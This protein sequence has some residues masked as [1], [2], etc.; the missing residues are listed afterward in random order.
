[1]GRE[2]IRMSIICAICNKK[3]S[4]WI[5]DFPVSK[6][7]IDKRI[8]AQCN[9]KLS[10]LLRSDTPENEI[11]IIEYLAKSLN[12][13]ES[14]EVQEYISQVIEDAKNN[15]EIRK[16]LIEE[17]EVQKQ[18]KAAAEEEQ[19]R[20]DFFDY[21]IHGENPLYELKGNRGRRLTVYPYKCVIKTD[22]TLGSLVTHNATDGEK[23]IYYKDVIGIQ[24][25]KPGL[26]IGF[27]QLETASSQGNNASSN[28]F[29]ENTFTYDAY[30]NEIYE[31][32]KY[33][34]SRL[35]E[36]KGM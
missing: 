23:T 12:G 31:V 25:K 8:C 30:N 13:I 10:K 33:I 4:G 21:T 15:V 24:F 20:L 22:V 6:E 28:F 32:Y 1:M 7:L 3:Q 2:N 14:V 26:S 27:L 35:D 17:Q 36:I 19:A 9:E 11:E 18:Q 16:Q 29:N 34:I 5:E